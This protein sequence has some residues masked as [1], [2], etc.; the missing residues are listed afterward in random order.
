MCQ[1]TKIPKLGSC[2]IDSVRYIYLSVGVQPIRDCG[3]QRCPNCL[4]E[5]NVVHSSIFWQTL[6]SNLDVRR[7][8]LISAVNDSFKNLVII[9][10]I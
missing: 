7:P 8:T 9:D 3:Y 10:S 2:T 5:R 6:K 1:K 4:L